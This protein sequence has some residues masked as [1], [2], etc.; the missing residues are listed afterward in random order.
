MKVCKGISGIRLSARD[1]GGRHHYQLWRQWSK[2]RE[3]EAPEGLA[4]GVWTKRGGEGRWGKALPRSMSNAIAALR[5]DPG[6]LPITQKCLKTQDTPKRK[7]PFHQAPMAWLPLS[8]KTGNTKALAW[9]KGKN[10]LV[11]EKVRGTWPSIAS[12]RR[13]NPP[14][15]FF[16]INHNWTVRLLFAW[17]V[18]S[19]EHL[20]SFG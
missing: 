14:W 7:R 12:C 15:F 20:F 2:P 18:L 19:F 1:V 3:L 17:H 13:G 4:A 16:D 10:A 8:K 6:F 5:G 11:E 9:R